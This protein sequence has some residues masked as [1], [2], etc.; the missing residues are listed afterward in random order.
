METLFRGSALVKSLKAPK[1]MSRGSCNTC[2]NKLRP[3]CLGFECQ[4]TFYELQ[5]F[6]PWSFLP[7]QL[8]FIYYIG[9]SIFGE[10]M[11]LFLDCDGIL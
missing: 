7:L 11:R 9:P 8:D 2:I 1:I 6:L 10:C 4:V 5:S 3:T